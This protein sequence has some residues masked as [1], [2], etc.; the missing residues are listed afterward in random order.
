MGNEQALVSLLHDCRNPNGHYEVKDAGNPFERDTFLSDRL[1]CLS[2]QVLYS[3]DTQIKRDSGLSS[4]N[5]RWG[6]FNCL[7]IMFVIA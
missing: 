6:R 4:G 1:E 7:S 3:V 5:V 2:R